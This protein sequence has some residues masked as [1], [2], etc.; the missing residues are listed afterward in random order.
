MN[1]GLQISASGALTAL[2]RQDVLTNNLANANTVG[3]KPDLAAARQ[4][5]TA[6]VEDRL[7]AMP[8]N[9][10]LE[11][12]GG[13]VFLERNRVQ[14]GQGA[15]ERTGGPLDVAVRG[16]GFFVVRDES[17]ATGDRLRLTRDGRFARD[18]RGRL[19][20]ATHGH[21]VMDTA[22]RPIVLNGAGPVT[23]D[24]DGTVR[25]GPVAVA[26]IQLAAVTDTARLDKLGHSLFRA[27]TGVVAQRR[28]AGGTLEQGFVEASGVDEIKT[29][30]QITAASRDVE[31]NIG[32]IQQAD[33]L[34]D[35]AINQLGRVT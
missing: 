19:V 24:A 20:T 11:R 33:R 34:M 26:Q 17:D 23:I 2:Y 4:R 15:L 16:E 32:M 12:L 1:Y 6:R 21:P 8:S 13:G 18:A 9:A 35:R 3:F 22:N 7:F 14:F 30:L 27:P 25:Q 31:A 5:D 29:M 10:L 28:Q